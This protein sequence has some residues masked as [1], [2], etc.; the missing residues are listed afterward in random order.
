MEG[1]KL[2]EQAEKKVGDVVYI[3]EV[4]RF[5]DGI[6]LLCGK[7]YKIEYIGGPN[8]SQ[9]IITDDSD[10]LKVFPMDDIRFQTNK[11]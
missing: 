1:K 9:F 6:P 2:S 10:E 11:P 5:P 7:G 3:T 4:A 8:Q